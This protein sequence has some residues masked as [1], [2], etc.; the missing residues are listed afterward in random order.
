MIFRGQ[1]IK[2]T[3]DS[4]SEKSEK[5]GQGLVTP[6]CGGRRLAADF[7][8]EKG[9]GE[10]HK[11]PLRKMDSP[12]ATLERSAFPGSSLGCP[13]AFYDPTSAHVSDRVRL[14]FGNR[15]GIILKPSKLLAE[16]ARS[17][18]PCGKMWDRKGPRLLG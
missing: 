14:N 6:D 18:F 12:R 1:E 11:I 17:S 5:F 10:N 8:P 3:L 16:E 15:P 7:A 4:L 9:E 13:G 2:G